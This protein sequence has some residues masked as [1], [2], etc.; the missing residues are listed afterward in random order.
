MSKAGKTKI[1]EE[2]T[3]MGIVRNE[4]KGNDGYYSLPETHMRCSASVEILQFITA[5]KIHHNMVMRALVSSG[6]STTFTKELS[7]ASYECV[8]VLSPCPLL[9]NEKYNDVSDVRVKHGFDAV[10]AWRVG[11]PFVAVCKCDEQ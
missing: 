1:E 4:L 3:A 9:T 2:S 8:S 7:A 5:F 6:D 10:R 11:K